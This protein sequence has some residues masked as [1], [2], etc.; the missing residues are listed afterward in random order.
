[1]DG[2]KGHERG[3]PGY[4]REERLTVPGMNRHRVTLKKRFNLLLTQEGKFI[5]NGI[6]RT[7]S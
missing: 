6:V 1:M 7:R 2:R 5:P 4:W 3:I